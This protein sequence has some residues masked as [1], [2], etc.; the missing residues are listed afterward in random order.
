[1]LPFVVDRFDRW[2]RRRY[3]VVEFTDDPDCLL[4][5]ALRRAAREVPLRD[6]S[7]VRAG[8]A[9]GELHLW[10]EQLP[11]FPREGPSFAWARKTSRRMRHSLC[12][13][14]VH[15]AHDPAW[16]QVAA[17]YADVPVPDGRPQAVVQRIASRY[18]FDCLPPRRSAPYWIRAVAE[19]VLLW[20]F[21]VTYNPAALR[22]QRF[23]RRR[24]QIWI[25]RP[26][27]M[28]R[29]HADRGAGAT[30]HEATGAIR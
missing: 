7:L 18:G 17:F 19:S 10:N 26:M 29:Y 14:A 24:Q 1:M 25:S 13:L 11:K 6:G 30:G 8:Q 3:H 23:V 21:A 16:R 4:R 15:V 5:V 28:A 20:G 9:V 27:L 22:R 12:L 2:L